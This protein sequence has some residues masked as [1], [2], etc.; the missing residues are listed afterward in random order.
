MFG[1]AA[2]SSVWVPYV[3]SR[4]NIGFSALTGLIPKTWYRCADSDLGAKRSKPN[5]YYFVKKRNT[6]CDTMNSAGDPCA[7]DASH[8]HDVHNLPGIL[9]CPSR[10]EAPALD[11]TSS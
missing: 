7:E 1:S 8:E 11:E 6:F 3:C 4:R 5:Q 10:L 2:N 9:G